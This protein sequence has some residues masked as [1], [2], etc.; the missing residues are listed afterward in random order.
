MNKKNYK[1][2]L[3]EVSI[4]TAMMV[5]NSESTPFTNGGMSPMDENGDPV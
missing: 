3:A 5:M 4:V 2:P 1:Q